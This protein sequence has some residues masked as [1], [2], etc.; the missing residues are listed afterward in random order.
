[1]ATNKIEDRDLGYARTIQRL[2]KLEALSFTVGIHDKDSKVYQRGQGDPVTTAQVGTFHEFGTLDK[3]ED[4][5]NTKRGER[6]VPQRSFLRST[7][8]ENEQKY[9]DQ[10]DKALGRS[11]DG[12][13][14]LRVGLG[15]VAS[16]LLGDVQKKI[17]RGV[18]PD[19]TDATKAAKGSTKPLIDDGPLRQSLSWEL[20]F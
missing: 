17:S 3:F 7:V 10:I 12:T 5:T 19:I 16:G 4:P 18:R 13:L 6:G 2:L 9:A 1:M 15:V 20:D 8:D 14:D 11:I